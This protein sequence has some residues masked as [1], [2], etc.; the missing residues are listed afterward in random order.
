M[1]ARFPTEALLKHDPSGQ[2]EYLAGDGTW[3]AGFEP[4]DAMILMD[5]NASEMSVRYHDEMG[6]WLAVYSYPERL[7]DQAP[8]DRIF[9]RTSKRLEGPWSEPESI[10]RVP[11]LN[12]GRASERD[13]N[14]FCYAAKEHPQYA[15][16]GRLL[17]T[18][19]C[20]LF[21][22]AGQDEWVVLS[23]LAEQMNLYRPRVVELPLP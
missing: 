8:S 11:E 6:A 3:R 19:V 7:P 9:V 18:Y 14:T 12:E 10:F 15:P 13:P 17:L 16:E 4:D 1:L 23:R 5:D 20:N 21:A 2:L 22:P